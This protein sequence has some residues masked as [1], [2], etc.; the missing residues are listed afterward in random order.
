MSANIMHEQKIYIEVTVLLYVR[1]KGERGGRTLTVT[2]YEHNV[3]QA[4]EFLFLLAYEQ[5]LNAR[6]AVDGVFFRVFLIGNLTLHK[7]S[8]PEISKRLK[9]FHVAAKWPRHI[10]SSIVIQ[11]HVRV[12]LRPCIY[13][14]IRCSYLRMYA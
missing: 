8:F 4:K 11:C 5:I 7:V 9:L 12:W 6:C 2:F 3:A 1:T 10:T 14:N 13:V